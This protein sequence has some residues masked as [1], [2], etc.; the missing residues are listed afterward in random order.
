MVLEPWQSIS[1][2]PLFQYKVFQVRKA[3]RLSPRTRKEVGL[4]ILDTVD[5]VNIVAFTNQQELILVRQ[6]RHGIRDFT[7]EIPGGVVHE[8]EEP[9]KAARRELREESG[10]VPGDLTR[11][12]CATPNP[13]FQ[14][15]RITTYLATGCRLVGDLVQD[16]GEDLEVVLVPGDEVEAKVRSGEIHHALVL[17][18]LYFHKLRN[19][20]QR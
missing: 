4:F 8:D 6:Y 11:I 16:Q 19:E 10:Y 3:V 13:A 5:W 20:C 17:A 7:L 9:E 2:E 14:T 18:G 1:E 15:N 12:G